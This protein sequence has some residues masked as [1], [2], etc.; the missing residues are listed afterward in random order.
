VRLFFFI[1]VSGKQFF[2]VTIVFCLLGLVYPDGVPEGM[3]SPF[4]GVLVGILLGGTPSVL[5][6]IYL[7]LKL[8]VLRRRAG[9]P[10]VPMSPPSTKG[11]ANPT[12]R[13]APSLRVV[14]GGAD[15]ELRKRRP[16]KD[17]RYLN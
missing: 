9:A 12:R 1:P 3:V 2:W 6:Q 8:A 13:G 7:R 10:P 17:K 5:R 15:D 16:P 14:Q 4:G 11:K